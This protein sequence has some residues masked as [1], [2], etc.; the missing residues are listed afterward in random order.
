M[1]STG[2]APPSTPNPTPGE[3]AIPWPD[4]NFI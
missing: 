1:N 4:P 3:K 2:N